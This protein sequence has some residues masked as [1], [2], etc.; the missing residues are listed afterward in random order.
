MALF[1]LPVGLFALSTLEGCVPLN[2]K[3]ILLLTLFS[4]FC[5]QKHSADSFKGVYCKGSQ[6]K[7]H[8]E[9][10]QPATPDDANVPDFNHIPLQTSNSSGSLGSGC[11]A[12]WERVDS[13][14]RIAGTSG[15]FSVCGVHCGE[16]G[17]LPGQ[18]LRPSC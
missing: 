3:H 12:H 4:V 17:V 1:A 7:H 2:M 16:A 8:L 10:R 6:R 18:W 13:F 15:P 9:C 11:T 5:G 14:V